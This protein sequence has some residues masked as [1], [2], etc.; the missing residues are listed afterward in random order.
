MLLNQ[1]SKFKLEGKKIKEKKRQKEEDKKSTKTEKYKITKQY[2]SMWNIQ[3][4]PTN[5]KKYI[6]KEYDII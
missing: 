5:K 2:L 4:S 6:E 3:R 1:Y